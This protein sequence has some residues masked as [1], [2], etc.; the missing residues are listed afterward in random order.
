M[1]K[2]L[3]KAEIDKVDEGRLGELFDIIKGF[4]RPEG[5]ESRP[6][7]LERLQEIEIDAPEV[8]RRTSICT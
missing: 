3:I 1:T 8:S 2:E 5:S 4:T 7:L 6:G